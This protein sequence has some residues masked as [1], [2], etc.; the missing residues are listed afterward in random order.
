LCQLIV[1]SNEELQK[2]AYKL[3]KKLIAQK[4]EDLSVRL[5]FTETSGIY[6]NQFCIS[7]L[8]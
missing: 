1:T 3:L 6:I 4:V 5:E 2:C 8:Y 7:K